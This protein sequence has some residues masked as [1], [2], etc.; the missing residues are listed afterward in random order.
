MA[1]GGGQR[2]KASLAVLEMN[3]KQKGPVQDTISDLLSAM[4]KI[5]RIEN[6]GFFYASN[7]V[8]VAPCTT[9]FTR[10]LVGCDGV[11]EQLT[12]IF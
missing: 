11:R 6:L 10:L 2:L 12:Q 4:I 3:D 5:D 9:R 8:M 1:K 7:I